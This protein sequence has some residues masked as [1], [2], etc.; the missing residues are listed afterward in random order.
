M[1]HDGTQHNDAIKEN[2]SKSDIK[3]HHKKSVRVIKANV[4]LDFET[5]LRIIIVLLQH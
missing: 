3:S 4:I 2:K 5:T 1:L